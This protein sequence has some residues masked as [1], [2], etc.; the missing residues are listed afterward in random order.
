MLA[1]RYCGA[2]ERARLGPVPARSFRAECDLPLGSA[3]PSESP[4]VESLG[5]GPH[6]WAQATRDPVRKH[7]RF[8]CE[9][10]MH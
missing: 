2:Y 5:A 9:P 8:N 4:Q 1:E 7:M 3:C 6:A 10:Y